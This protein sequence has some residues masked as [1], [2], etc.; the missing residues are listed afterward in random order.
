VDDLT[1]RLALQSLG[2]EETHELRRAILQWWLLGE[3]FGGAQS[4]ADDPLDQ[5]RRGHES[6]TTGSP[7]RIEPDLSSFA[8]DVLSAA[9]QC[10]AGEP[11]GI[12]KV[13]I[14]RVRRRLW[15]DQGPTMRPEGAAFTQWLLAANRQGLIELTRADMVE[16][17]DPVELQQSQLAEGNA[18]YHFV[19]LPR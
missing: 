14:E 18:V 4:E 10:E 7:E 12:G 15:Q 19:R 5:T 16:A 8:A 17:F 3:A 13:F 6:A 9:A 2:L 1:K 11:M